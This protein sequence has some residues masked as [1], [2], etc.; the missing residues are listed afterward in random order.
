MSL[1]EIDDR[2]RPAVVALAVKPDQHRFVD[3]V[4]ASLD[5]AATYERPPWCR[6][7]YDVD[8]PV[9]FVMLADDDP[10]C[11][12]RYYLWRLLIDARYQ[13]LGYGRAALDLVT[14][15]VRTRPGGDVL[16]TSVAHYDD[17]RDDGSPLDFYLRCGFQPTG[18]LHDH[19]IVLRLTLR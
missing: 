3:G 9:G 5:E 10:T 18:E 1:R 12:W 19:E 8:E 13:G 4:Q 7:I 14:A 15:Y 16:M 11:P 17:D 6:A 2:N